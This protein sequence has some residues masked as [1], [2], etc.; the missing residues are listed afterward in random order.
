MGG[1]VKSVGKIVTSVLGMEAPQAAPQVQQVLAE[2]PKVEPLPTMPTPDDAAI[3]TQQRKSVATQ[4]RRQGR[5]STILT[6]A[7]DEGLGG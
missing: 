6:A 1:V 7:G 5:A 3:R 2:P 4:R